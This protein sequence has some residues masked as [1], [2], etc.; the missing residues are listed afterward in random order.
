MLT[1]RV[2]DSASRTRQGPRHG[3]HDVPEGQREWAQRFA[4]VPYTPLF[5][6]R[7]G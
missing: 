5:S 6:A 2:V 3:D 1:V 4:G 7:L